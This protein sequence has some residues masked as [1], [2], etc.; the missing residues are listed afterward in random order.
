MKDALT[1]GGKQSLPKSSWAQS[2]KG[3]DNIPR[4]ETVV[5][6]SLK[7]E[8]FQNE[9]LWLFVRSFITWYPHWLVFLAMFLG[10]N[11][12]AAALKLDL[13]KWVSDK[14]GQTKNC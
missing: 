4:D 12:A 3:F 2:G 13:N 10:T 11:S 7:K 6:D 5:A 1:K 14:F 9:W 8:T